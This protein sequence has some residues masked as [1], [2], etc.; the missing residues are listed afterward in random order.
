MSPPAEHPRDLGTGEIPEATFASVAAAVRP[1]HRVNSRSVRMRCLGVEAIGAP[2]E[3]IFSLQVGR[4]AGMDWTW[5]GPLAH[6][7]DEAGFG[8]SGEVV[9]VDPVECRVF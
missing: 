4:F 9:E 2:D 7:R 3:G 8:W 5:G 6:R 1:E